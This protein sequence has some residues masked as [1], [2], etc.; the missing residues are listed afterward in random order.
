MIGGILLYSYI[1]YVCVLTVLSID[2]LRQRH[3]S[4][5]QEDIEMINIRV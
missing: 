2:Y 1:S 5:R 4:V 3:V